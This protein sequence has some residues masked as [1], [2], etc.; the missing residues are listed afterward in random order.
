V[1][2]LSRGARLVQD[3]VTRFGLDLTD[4][5]V[6][7]EAASGPY[8]YTPLVAAA[9][10][11]EEVIAVTADSIYATAA[12]VA[13][14]TSAAAAELDLAT[15]IHITE[16]G[17]P[18]EVGRSDIVTNTGFVRPIDAALVSMMKRTAVVPLM[19]ETWELR[20]S[21]VDLASCRRHGILVLG[22][23][24][25]RAPL[26]FHPYL[27]LVAL[28]VLFELSLEA[29]RTRV[30]LLGTGE[31]FGASIAASLTRAGA[32]VDWYSADSRGGRYDDL[33]PYWDEHGHEVDAL[34]LAE[35]RSPRP[36]IGPGGY[37]SYESLR[38]RRPDLGV[39]VIAGH[40]DPD[41]LLGSGLRTFPGRI[42][43]FGYMSY[44]PSD[45]GPRPV[46]ELYAAGLRVGQ[47]MARARLRGLGLDDARDY[48]LARS[49]AMGF[50]VREVG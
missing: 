49:P 14:A 15:R 1:S 22:T 36:L 9:A 6:Y 48:A 16:R 4:L 35:H 46:L 5:T 10:G 37:L 8:L 32:T 44:Q 21:E 19:W 45:L 28:K 7:T 13:G 11:A 12:D 33:A 47:E 43:P 34:I 39:G 30:L 17:R 41:G 24:E 27:G 18:D 50:H 25:G 26:D 20:A 38:A 3:C 29:Y 40:H 2:S 23:D 42:R 31:V